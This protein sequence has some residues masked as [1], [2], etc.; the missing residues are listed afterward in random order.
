MDSDDAGVAAIERLCTGQKPILVSA[1]ENLNVDIY[2]ANLPEGIKDP[3]DFL[4][5][6]RDADGLEKMFR[7]DV[8]QNATEWSEWYM[9]RLLATHD[10]D[11]GSLGTLSFSAV[12]ERLASFLATFGN[13]EDLAKRAST[14]AAKLAILV[15]SDN[16]ESL[17]AVSSTVCIQLESE[18]IE[19]ATNMVQSKS[20][21]SPKGDFDR[22]TGLWKPEL[23]I[24]KNLEIF[25]DISLMEGPWKD[26]TVSDSYRRASGVPE[27]IGIDQ[28]AEAGER[29][30]TR[31]QKL[32]TRRQRTPLKRPGGIN[33][34]RKPM[35]SH[36]G[37]LVSNSF[38]EKWLGATKH[39]VCLFVRR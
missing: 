23:A 12:F 16:N 2:V 27:L 9:N 15:S 35:T 18:L 29:Y 8:V 3:A 7:E 19:K 17:D 22:T 1:T 13:K 32:P 10:P 30:R 20:I 34:V 36:V 28:S 6:H 31:S 11:A 24:P 26:T 14:V 37:G 21:Q 33:S 4:E 5:Q 39:L 25:D 38:D